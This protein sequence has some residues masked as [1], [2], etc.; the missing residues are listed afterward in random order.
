MSVLCSGIMEN[1]QLTNVCFVVTL[2]FWWDGW[3]LVCWA[4]AGSANLAIK[5]WSVK[6]KEQAGL[7]RKCLTTIAKAYDNFLKAEDLIEFDTQ[8]LQSKLLTTI[9]INKLGKNHRQE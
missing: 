8:S 6:S 5:N 4:Y 7:A 2:L 9:Y 1:H 3:E